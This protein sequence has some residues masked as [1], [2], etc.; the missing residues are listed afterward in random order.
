M[1]SRQVDEATGQIIV[2]VNWQGNFSHLPPSYYADTLNDTR[3]SVYRGK[4]NS[5]SRERGIETR[6]VIFVP[7]NG[8]GKDRQSYTLRDNSVVFF[9]SEI[10]TNGSGSISVLGLSLVIDDDYDHYLLLVSIANLDKCLKI[11]K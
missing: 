8:L 2:S 1:C 3:L 10:R 6:G 11:L 4:A 7:I 5:T 9:L